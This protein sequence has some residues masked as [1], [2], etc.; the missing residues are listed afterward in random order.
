MNIEDKRKYHREYQRKYR[1]R[2]SPQ[3]REYQ[4]KYRDNNKDKRKNGMLKLRFDLTLEEYNLMLDSQ[5]G[6]CKICSM[7]ETTRKNNSDEV[8]MLCVDHD[9]NTGKVRGLLCNKCN[10]ALGHYE[11]TKPRTQ[12][13]EKYLE[14]AVK[15]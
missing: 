2:N 3:E 14:E 6:V 10:K 11:A 9:H 5:G 1:L 13:F 12:E 8:R 15:L 4:K 7:P